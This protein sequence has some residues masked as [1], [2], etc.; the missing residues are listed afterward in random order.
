MKYDDASWHYGGDFPNDLPPKAG[1]T[2]IGMFV[3]WCILN[4][5]GGEVHFEDPAPLLPKLRARSITPGDYFTKACD[6]KF[7]DEDLTDEGNAFAANY[8]EFEDGNYIHDYERILGEHTH[9]LYHVEDTWENF[10]KL[11][12]VIRNRYLAASGNL[13]PKLQEGDSQVPEGIYNI[14]SLNPNSL[15]HLALRVGYPNEWDQEHARADGRKNLGGDIMIHGGAG[16]CGCLAMGDPAAEELFVLAARTGIDNIRLLISPV[17]FRVH[18]LPNSMVPV[19]A[20]SD[21][22]YAELKSE[23]ARLPPGKEIFK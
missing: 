1:A 6:E 17:D 10:D 22:L 23:L 8:Y 15:Y 9:T 7:T 19:P 4:G 2:H 12:S 18:A 20:W 3:V 16:S 5:L 11:A 14:E 13:G 21:Q